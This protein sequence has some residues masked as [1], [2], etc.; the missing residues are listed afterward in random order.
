MPCDVERRLVVEPAGPEGPVDPGHPEIHAA[1]SAAVALHKV[2]KMLGA[3]N[4]TGA[5]P[6]T[7]GFVLTPEEIDAASRRYQRLLEAQIAQ[8]CHCDH[9]KTV[10]FGRGPETAPGQE[11]PQ[12]LNA[13]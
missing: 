13:N 10:S 7:N 1:P 4:L 5:K 3:P 8:E 2:N 12:H 11:I 9:K 6:V